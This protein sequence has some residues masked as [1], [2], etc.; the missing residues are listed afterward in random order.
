MEPANGESRRV[1]YIGG[2]PRWQGLP[3]DFFE[4][5][6]RIANLAG[7]FVSSQTSAPVCVFMSAGGGL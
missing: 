5:E 1:S 3:A 4:N 2:I 6:E 7:S